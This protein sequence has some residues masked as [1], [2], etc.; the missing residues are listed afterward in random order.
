MVNEGKK[1]FACL[2][3]Q[4]TFGENKNLTSHMKTQNAIQSYTCSICT[5]YKTDRKANLQRHEV[6]CAKK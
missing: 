3:C 5:K 6:K 2:V 4:K 1:P